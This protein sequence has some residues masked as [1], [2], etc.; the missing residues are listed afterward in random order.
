MAK[1]IPIVIL[2]SALTILA[3]LHFSSSSPSTINLKIKN[4]TFSLEIAR[5]PLQQS[6]GLSHRNSLCPA[7]GMIFIYNQE[8]PL[9]FWMKNT[10]IPL[11]IIWLNQNGT[12]VDIKTGQPQSS[13]ILQPQKVAQYV[14]ELNRGAANLAIGDNIDLSP[15]FS[16]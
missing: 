11:D 14:I 4:K 9:P 15:I 8:Q 7:C 6:R 10:N 13:T 1:I 5:T 2:V 12:I 16:L 3:C